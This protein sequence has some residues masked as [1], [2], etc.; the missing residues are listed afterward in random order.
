MTFSLPIRSDKLPAKNPTI[1]PINKEADK[2]KPISSSFKANS[3]C[4]NRAKKGQTINI[5]K[6]LKKVCIIIYQTLGSND[7]V[8]CNIKSPFKIP[9]L[10]KYEFVL[11]N[12][13]SSYKFME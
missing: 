7:F 12:I 5:V 9:K 11:W 6:R 3:L 2:K 8:S 10:C 4:S 1:I 13:F